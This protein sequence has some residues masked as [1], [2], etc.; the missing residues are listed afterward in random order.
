[1]GY[2]WD[3]SNKLIVF[4]T[5]EE[6]ILS[7][8]DWTFS[9]QYYAEVIRVAKGSGVNGHYHYFIGSGISYYYYLRGFWDN[10]LLLDQKIL[11]AAQTIGE[12][13]TEAVFIADIVFLLSRR[14]D[15]AEAEK[16]L[17][18]LDEI[19][20]SNKLMED[21]LL[22]LCYAT[23]EYL[24]T[25]HDFENA[26]QSWM[27]AQS[28]AEKAQ[29]TPL[30]ISSRIWRA[31]CLYK[32]GS[33]LEAQNLLREAEAD[34]TQ[35]DF[36]SA[37]IG[38]TLWQAKIYIDQGRF[39]LALEKLERSILESRKFEW[40]YVALVQQTYARLHT[41]RGEL[42][43]AHASL[44]EVIDLFERMGMRRELAEAREELARL[45]AQMAAAAE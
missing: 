30:Y 31:V 5:E 10:K 23:A 42:P 15:I 22:P 12:M 44:T 28:L 6:T 14:G 35:Q 11:L 18:R 25:K 2:C 4:K 45:E 9:H 13:A 37:I 41:L 20:R 3:D 39:E 27:K 43:Q 26:Q 32:L 19:H 21:T 8:V 1:V 17:H 16:Y 7:A 36:A 24:T 40:R 34:A 33:S 38:A 29:C